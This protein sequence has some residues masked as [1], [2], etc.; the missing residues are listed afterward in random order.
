MLTTQADGTITESAAR[1]VGSYNDWD[2]VVRHAI[3]RAGLPDPIVTQ[4]EAQEEDEDDA[5]LRAFLRAWHAYKPKLEGSATRIV[6]ELFGDNGREPAGGDNAAAFREAMM[7]LTGGEVG[8]CP[9]PKQLGYRLKDARDK[10][11][12]GYRLVRGTKRKDGIRYAVEADSDVARPVLQPTVTRQQQAPLPLAT[13]D[14][15]VP[16]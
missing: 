14:D 6:Q 15:Q 9:S 8:K 1:P 2:R 7:E 11:I 13:P 5:K 12:G 10:K 3:L 4:D 16:F